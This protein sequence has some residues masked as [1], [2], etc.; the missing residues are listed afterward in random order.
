MKSGLQMALELIELR[1]AYQEKQRDSA[2]AAHNYGSAASYEGI[3]VG[4]MM[5]AKI[6]KEEIKRD[7]LCQ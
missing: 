2:V 7:E 5:A 6:I 4:L 1:Q 3:A